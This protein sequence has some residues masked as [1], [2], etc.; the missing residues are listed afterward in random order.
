MSLP[1]LAPFGPMFFFQKKKCQ[2]AGRLVRVSTS[3]VDCGSPPGSGV[4]VMYSLQFQVK[5]ANCSSLDFSRDL[6]HQQFQ[7]ANALNGRF[8]DLQG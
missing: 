4:S 2:P 6:F 7:I 5:A 8:L 1:H 3:K